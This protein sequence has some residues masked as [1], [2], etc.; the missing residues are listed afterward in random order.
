[1][2]DIIGDIHGYA[3]PLKKLLEKLGYAESRGSWHHPVN[4]VIFVGDYIDRG[5]AIRETL[6]IVKGMTDSSNAIALMGNHELNAL[7]Y[8]CK[9][10]G[11]PLRRHTEKN[12]K[13]HEHTLEQFFGHEAEW[14]M[15]LQWFYTLPLFFEDDGIRAVHACWDE[16]HI[17]WLKDN[18]KPIAFPFQNR[19]YYKYVMNAELLKTSHNRQSQAY[20]VINDTL[21][22]KEFN[23]PGQ[24]EWADREGLVRKSNRVKWWV[25]PRANV[26]EEWLFDCPIEMKTLT[27][28]EGYQPYVYPSYAPPVFFGHYWLEDSYPVVQEK[29][30]VCLDYSIANKGCLVAYRWVAEREPGINNFVKVRYKE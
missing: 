29:N 24:Y 8:H 21:K 23:I 10:D 22:G 26:Y 18:C 27:I 19:V 28:D 3:E 4:K 6:Q 9:V 20:H 2:Y 7:A 25:D 30:I 12:T 11:F 16:D 15:Y 17:Q 5:P 14:Q 1:M 13:Q